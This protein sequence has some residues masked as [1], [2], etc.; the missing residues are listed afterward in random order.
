MFISVLVLERRG[1]VFL[2]NLKPQ[3]RI[4][5]EV[6]MKFTLRAYVTANRK[7]K[8]LKLRN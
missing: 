6:W 8:K 3:V 5:S 7:K 2:E 4:Y 1:S